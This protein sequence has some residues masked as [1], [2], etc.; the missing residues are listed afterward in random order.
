MKTILNKLLLIAVASLGFVTLVSCSDDDDATLDRLFRPILKDV[1]TGLGAENKPYMTLEWDKY[2]S[3]NMYVAR[4]ES[5]DGKDVKE[6]TT[7]ENTCTFNDLAYDQDYNVYIYSMNTETGLQSKEYTTIATTPDLPTLLAN[8]STSNIIDT[9]V[10]VKWSDGAVYDSLAV[11]NDLTNELAAYHLVTPE[12]LT[13]ENVIIRNLEPS[14]A[15]R[16]EAYLDKA[17]QG[18]KRFTTAASENYEGTVID[19][20]SMTEEESY[21]W[22]SMSS[23]SEYENAI[24][25]LVKT[26]PD[27]DITIVFQGGVKYRIPTVNIPSTTGKIKFVTGLTLSGNAEFCVTG[28]MAVASNANVNELAFD[29]ISFIDDESK[30]KTSSNYGGTYLFNFNQA[31]ATCGKINIKDS[32]I[33]YKRGVCRIQ[34]TASIDEFCIDNCI[35]DSIGGY[36]ITNADNANALI[37]NVVVKNSTLSNCALVFVAT[38]GPDFKSVTVENCTFVYSVAKSRYLFNFKGKSV[39]DGIVLKNC[40][41]GVTGE[42]PKKLSD[43]FSGWVGNTV[44]EASGLYFTNDLKWKMTTAEPPEPEAQFDGIT[45]STDTK[46]TFA[47]PETGDFRI[48]NTAELKDSH[49]GDPR[50]Y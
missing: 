34:T 2:A 6:I 15:Y 44:P 36:G 24:D 9:Q 39:A 46:G 45:L 11:V 19:L 37:N 17:Y 23:T 42:T 41:L 38:K 1:V 25:S 4:I 28:S 3:A 40:L 30:P 43:A 10:R 13:A 32:E 18:K 50:W 47:N 31:N 22:F 5:T 49:P 27:Q 48:I 8:I 21:K 16:V 35:V 20:R 12:D 33:K 7:E 29:K 26:Y 14:T